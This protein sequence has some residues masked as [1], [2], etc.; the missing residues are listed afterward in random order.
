[1]V[2]NDILLDSSIY[3][4]RTLRVP[5][6]VELLQRQLDVSKQLGFPMVRL[7]SDVSDVVT[8]ATLP[9]AERLGIVM[10]AEIHGGMSFDEPRA[11]KWVAMMRRLQSE[12]LGLTIDFGIFCDRHPRLPIDYFTSIGLTPAV[13]DKVEELWEAN[14]DFHQVLAANHHQFPPELSSLIRGPVD[15]E[16]CIFAGGYENTP[17]QVLDENIDYIKHFH[18]KFFE[19]LPD[20]TEFSIDV[21]KILTRLNQLGYDGYVASEYE[22]NRF[23]AIGQDVDDQ[24]QLRAHQDLLAAHINDGK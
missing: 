9:Y 21:P 3:R 14:G 15:F 10:T 11:A 12:Y 23:T 8:E 16:F 17:L 7:T 4:N 24:G 18:G 13:A 22:G 19:M 5:E 6:Q 2:C 1:M 20:G